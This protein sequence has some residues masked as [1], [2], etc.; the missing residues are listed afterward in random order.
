MYTLSAAGAGIAWS[1]KRLGHRLDDRGVEARFPVGTRDFLFA[2]T[3]TLALGPI[4]P[5]INRYRG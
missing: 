2:V 5:P 4:Q 1:V 3:P